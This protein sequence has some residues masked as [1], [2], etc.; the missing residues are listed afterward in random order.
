MA[1]AGRAGT[2]SEKVAEAFGAPAALAVTVTVAAAM[3]VALVAVSGIASV[4]A[5]LLT[6]GALTPAGSPLRLS[7]TAP[8]TFVRVMLTVTAS[9][10]PGASVSCPGATCTATV[11]VGVVGGAGG[12]A[13][14]SPPPPQA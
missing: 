10:V 3:A 11:G 7:V 14:A 1:G 8:V 12:P 6:E 2:T 4:A 5:L 13:G 9:M